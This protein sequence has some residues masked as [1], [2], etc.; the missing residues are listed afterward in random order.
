MTQ[1]FNVSLAKNATWDPKGLRS[2]F[3]YRDLGIGKATK[4]AFHAHVIRAREATSEG[5]GAHTHRLD[6]Q[7]VYVIRG[8][9]TF[10]YAGEGE[11]VFGP[12]DCVLQPPG[13]R[14]ELKSCSDDLELLEITAPEDFETHEA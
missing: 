7:M 9:V 8:S 6:F 1:D 5:T 10:E 2:F 12:G 4:G 13:I 11:F 14:H 3:E